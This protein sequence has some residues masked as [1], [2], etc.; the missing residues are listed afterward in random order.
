LKKN[1]NLVEVAVTVSPIK[2]SKGK[3]IGVSAISRDITEQKRAQESL[4]KHEEQ[5]RLAQKM[6]AIGRLAGGVAHDF[7]N[8]LSVIGGNG[9][10]LMGSL[11]EG[12]P[13]REEVEEIKKAVHRGA[14]LTQ[15]LLVF[16]KKQVSQPQA[17]NLNELSSEMS[18]MLKRLIDATIDLSII[19]NK[20]LKLIHSDPGQIQQVILNLV[21]NARDAM[22][23][24]GNL[25]I[26]TQN[27]DASEIGGHLGPAIPPGAY[28]RLSVTDTGTGM[29]AETQKHVF[30]PFFTTKAGKGTGFFHLLPGGGG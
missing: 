22:P 8:L 30:E 20:D 29:D 16:G 14:E 28:V 19:Q 18:K 5:M 21:L 23:K 17:V 3:I 26:E 9:D 4:K 25:I 27:I 13:H 2:D 1:G 10:F 15:Q 6:D 24:G 11:A 12:D 7:N